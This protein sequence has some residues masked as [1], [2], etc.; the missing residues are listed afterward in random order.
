MPCRGVHFALTATESTALLAASSDAAVLGVVHQEIEEVW[1]EERLCETDKAWDAIHRCLAGGP[2]EDDGSILS[3]CILGGRQ[4]HAGDGSIVSYL[5]ASEV[6]RLAPALEVIDEPA[7][8]QRYD[9]IGQHGY[10]GPIGDEDFEYTWDH[11]D[12][13]RE[14]FRD[15]AAKGR[16]TVLTVDQ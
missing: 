16:P 7:L 8:R 1:D 2:L 12:A 6:A 11:F 4:L 9:Q 13:L 15:A 3:K 5:S 10:E 14:F